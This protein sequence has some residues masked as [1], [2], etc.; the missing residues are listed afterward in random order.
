VALRQFSIVI[1]VVVAVFLFH[2][3]AR[4]LR[5]GAALTIAVGIACIALA[6]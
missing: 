2:E 6:G 3:P 5:I 4:G 1:G